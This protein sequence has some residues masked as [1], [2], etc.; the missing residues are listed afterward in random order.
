MTGGLVRAGAGGS[1]PSF[2][3]WEA[4]EGRES[5]DVRTVGALPCPRV[6]RPIRRLVRPRLGHLRHP[7][8]AGGGHSAVDSAPCSCQVTAADGPRQ[9]P[10]LRA[11]L[12]LRL[13]RPPR[14]GL[15]GAEAADGAS[16][17][18][19]SESGSLSKGEPRTASAAI[20]LC[21]ADGGLGAGRLLS[22][23]PL[24]APEPLCP[25]QS[26]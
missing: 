10:R 4:R 5:C 2:V 16:A 8:S 26:P 7:W 6:T 11:G 14:C 15:S 3:S 22:P 1:C 9:R 25:P 12:R 21:L 18:P 20:C 19:L 17:F 13:I 24:A 23:R